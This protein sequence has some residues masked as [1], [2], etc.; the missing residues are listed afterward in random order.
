MRY[1]YT[2]S[3]ISFQIVIRYN[4]SETSVITHEI[5]EKIKIRFSNFESR[6]SIS[7]RYN[8]K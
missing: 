7:V 2:R 8:G 4:G 5:R 3:D 1:I 6:F